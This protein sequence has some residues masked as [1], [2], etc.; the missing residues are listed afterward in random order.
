MNFLEI[1]IV[2]NKMIRKTKESKLL[3]DSARIRGLLIDKN[4]Q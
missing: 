4:G 3:Y 1:N 2:F